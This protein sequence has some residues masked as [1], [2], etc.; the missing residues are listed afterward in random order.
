MLLIDD[1]SSLTLLAYKIS[2]MISIS[3]IT[4]AE[5]VG[6]FY[7]VDVKDIF[8]VKTHSRHIS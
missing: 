3:L 4:V 7:Y 1:A 5:K 6:S 8:L 2:H